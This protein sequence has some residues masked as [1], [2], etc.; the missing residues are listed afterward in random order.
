MLDIYKAS[1]GSGKTYILVKEYIKKSL[2]SNNRI[3][4]KSLLAITFTNKAASE[5][6]TRIISTL[7]VFSDEKNNIQE[8][9]FKQ[10]YNDL[11]IEL[12]YSD[13]QLVQRSKQVLLDIIHYY[14]LFS[15]STI[16]KF[17]HKIIRAF[18]Y[19]LELPSNFSVEMDQ[20]KIIKDGVIA[21][22]DEVGF[23]SILTQ[24]LLDYSYYKTEQNKNW[25]IQEDLLELSKQLFK[26]QKFLVIHD[27]TDV[28]KIKKKPK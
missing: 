4:H 25:D 5:M 12:N 13:I 26:D 11:K 8:T 2:S 14:S 20:N 10:L 28:K 22:I 17:I 23:D 27:L 7:F 6:K 21:L 1:A 18:S 24:D 3:S 15:V 9:S 16:D 19:E